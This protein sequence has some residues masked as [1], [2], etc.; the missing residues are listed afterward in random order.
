MKK[1]NVMLLA[2]LSVSCATQN[3]KMDSDEQYRNLIVGTWSCPMSSVEDGV[4]MDMDIKT[5]YKSDGT[6]QASGTFIVDSPMASNAEFQFTATGSWRIEQQSVFDVTTSMHFTSNTH[7]E[8]AEHFNRADLATLN[9]EEESEIVELDK[10]HFRFRSEE[11]TYE[12]IR[13]Q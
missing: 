8:M 6:S 12:C 3:T 10:R 1:L 9:E 7:P 13:L 4:K 11:E 2:V 5:I